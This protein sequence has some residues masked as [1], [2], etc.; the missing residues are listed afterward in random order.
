MP[1]GEFSFNYGIHYLFVA[2]MYPLRNAELL[3]IGWCLCGCGGWARSVVLFPWI[4]SEHEHKPD[5]SECGHVLDP[6]QPFQPEDEFAVLCGVGNLRCQYELPVVIHIQLYQRI[7]EWV[8]E[9]IEGSLS[10][11]DV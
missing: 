8:L 3:A 11:C 6:Q 1:R 4:Y 7:R 10:F 2:N 5:C 9:L